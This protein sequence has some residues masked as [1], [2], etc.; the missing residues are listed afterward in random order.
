LQPQADV[1]TALAIELQAIGD[2]GRA[3]RGSQLEKCNALQGVPQNA[4]VARAMTR[5]ILM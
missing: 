5:A 4:C 3:E 1:V 2:P